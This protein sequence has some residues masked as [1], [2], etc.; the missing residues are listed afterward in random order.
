MS[1]AHDLLRLHVRHLL[2]GPV[3]RGHRAE[4]G[5]TDRSV[6]C[7]T[8]SDPDGLWHGLWIADDPHLL[9]QQPRRPVVT[10]FRPKKRSAKKQRDVCWGGDVVRLSHI[11][12]E[13]FMISQIH[14]VLL[15]VY[16]CQL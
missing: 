2:P 6:V 11:Q 7:P 3:D 4:S 9:P 12:I 16:L 8:L 1:W 13:I 10:F 15:G 5:S 14:S